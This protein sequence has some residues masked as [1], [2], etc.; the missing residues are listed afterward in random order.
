MSKVE[1]MMKEE[2]GGSGVRFGL[3]SHSPTLLLIGNQINTPKLGLF[4]LVW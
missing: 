3:I 1:P 4:C 2:V